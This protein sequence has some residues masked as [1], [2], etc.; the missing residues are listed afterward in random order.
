MEFTAQ[1]YSKYSTGRMC[2]SWKGKEWGGPL[3][4]ASPSPSHH[5]KAVICCPIPL[6]FSFL[7]WSFYVSGSQAFLGYH[8]KNVWDT[9]GAPAPVWLKGPIWGTSKATGGLIAAPILG[10]EAHGSITW[11]P[12]YHIAKGLPEIKWR[13]TEERQSCRQNQLGIRRNHNGGLGRTDQAIPLVSSLLTNCFPEQTLTESPLSYSQQ[14]QHYSCA[15]F[16]SS[17]CLEPMSTVLPEDCL[18]VY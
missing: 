6:T 14:R 18:G 16:P 4:S 12:D 13:D 10:V 9:L 5:W 2:W 17:G 1:S 15:N 7:L 8:P 3:G 11:S